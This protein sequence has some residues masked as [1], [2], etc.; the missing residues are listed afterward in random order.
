MGK[1]GRKQQERKGYHPWLPAHKGRLQ[2][3]N[4]LPQPRAFAKRGE[5]QR[6]AIEKD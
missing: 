1:K 6:T 3:D 4:K 2:T 5:L